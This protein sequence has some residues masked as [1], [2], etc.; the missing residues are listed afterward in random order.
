[1]T[2]GRGGRD[3][4]RHDERADHDMLVLVREMRSVR[5]AR[6]WLRAFLG[7]QVATARPTTPCW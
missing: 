7:D 5:R 3:P 4:I 6:E 2:R 1:M